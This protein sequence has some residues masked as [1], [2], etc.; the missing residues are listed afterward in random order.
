MPKKKKQPP[1]DNG[2]FYPCAVLGCEQRGE[3]KAPRSPSRPD[4][5]Q[6]LCLEHVREFNKAWNFFEGMTPVQIEAYIQDAVTGHR[7]TWK[8]GGKGK[9]YDTKLLERGLYRLFGE[10]FVSHGVKAPPKMPARQRKALADLEFD[11]PATEIEIKARYKALV[12]KYHPDV[13]KGSKAS[14][15]RF[16]LITNAYKYLM[17]SLK[18]SV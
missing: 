7:P 5:Y 12:K 3:H 16:K 14:E 8:A 17:Q 6:W 13:N 9:L 10:S 15:E 1:I 2:P 18:T 4:E 11:R